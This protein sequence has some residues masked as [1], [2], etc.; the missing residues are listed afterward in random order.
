MLVPV[1]RT[2]TEKL[3]QLAAYVVFIFW[4]T[5]LPFYPL[6]LVVLSNPLPTD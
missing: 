3:Q 2:P 1:V 4:L 6:P 5:H